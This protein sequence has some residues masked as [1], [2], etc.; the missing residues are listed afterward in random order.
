M[1]TDD[2]R[3]RMLDATLLAFADD[4]TMSDA[5]DPTS[6]H[7]DGKGSRCQQLDVQCNRMQPALQQVIAESCELVRQRFAATFC[8]CLNCMC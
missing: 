7:A 2:Q 1:T 3:R 8:A 4:S 5:Q 6:G